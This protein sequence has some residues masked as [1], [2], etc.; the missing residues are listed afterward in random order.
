[1]Q[2]GE[3]V[4]PGTDGQWKMVPPDNSKVVL[5]D[6][7][8]H[9]DF[10]PRMFTDSNGNQYPKIEALSFSSPDL[11]LMASLP[12]RADDPDMDCKIVLR[13]TRLARFNVIDQTVDSSKAL[14]W[15]VFV[16][17]RD[18][19]PTSSWASGVLSLM[20]QNRDHIGWRSPCLRVAT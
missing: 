2:L 10:A 19:R 13:P 18:E 4:T 14:D 16:Q 15:E 17:I 5:T 8:G 12:I 9:F 20:N 1:M 7:D 3:S 11:K 6:A